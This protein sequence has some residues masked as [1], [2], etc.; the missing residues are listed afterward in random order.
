MNT[1]VITFIALAFFSA[2][3][4]SK[5]SKQ[6]PTEGTGPWIVNVYYK[7]LK[8]LQ[9]FAKEQEPWSVNTK[10]SYFTTEVVNRI[11]YQKLIND[12]F[13]IEVNTKRMKS[14]LVIKNAI[15]KAQ[16]SSLPLDTKTVPGLA[17]YRT[18]EETFATMDQLATTYPTL[19]TVL[20]VGDTWNKIDSGGSAGY[21]IRVLKI[22]NTAISG[23]KPVLFIMSSIHAREMAPAELNTRFAEYLLNNYG[24]NADVTW[25]VNNREIHLLLQGNPDGRKIA[26]TGASKRKNEDNIFCTNQSTKGVDMNRNFEWMWNQGS[27]SSDVPCEQTFRGGTNSATIHDYEPEN[28]AINTHMNDIFIDQRG[29]GLS[30]PAPNDTTGVYIDIHSYSELVLWPYGYDSPGV[31]PEAPNHNQLQT[32]GRKFAWYNDYLPEKSNELYGA[33]GASDDNAYGQLGIASYTFELGTSFFQDCGTFENTILPDNLKALIYAAKVA[34]TPY[35]TASG[36]DIDNLLVSS[37]TDYIFIGDVLTVS[38]VATDSHFSHNLDTVTHPAETEQNISKAEFF[39][40]E[41]PWDVGATPIL[42]NAVDGNFN[43]VTENF[44]GQIDTTGMSLGQHVVYV[45]TTDASGVTGVPYAKFFTIVDAADLGTLS[46]TITDAATNLP[47]DAVLLSYNG[48]QANSNASGN[49]SFTSLASTTDLTVSKQGYASEI[50]NNVSIVASQTT[51][52]NIQLQ[53]LCALLD[54]SSETFNVIADAQI[55][56]WS[57][58]FAAGVDDWSI[59]LTGGISATHAF[60]TSDPGATTDKWL[61]TP[62]MDLSADSVLEFWHKFGFEGTSTFYDGGI[63]E[64][65]TNASYSNWVDLGS[66]ASVGGY[67]VT[68]NSGNPLGAIQ[69]WGGSQPAFSRVEISLSSFAGT[70]AKIRWRMGADSS[71]GGSAPWVIDDIKVL[72]PNVCTLVNPD[73]LFSSGFEF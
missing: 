19:A 23:T 20:D 6:L 40:D 26:E 34:D 7:D 32:L 11:Q 17:C 15:K 70:S 18:V 62:A 3:V 2:L 48:L 35:I 14:A 43:A 21:D 65:A 46:G 57:H 67:N 29:P 33:D 56:G 27:G 72:D 25:L 31:I 50:I 69:A 12:G 59:N 54:E 13:L 53:P 36:P 4:F 16:R 28:L 52:Q 37:N 55:V 60:S 63:L 30:D 71:V 61:I 1:K 47:V 24:S 41:N 66:L 45:Q 42:L 5:P 64:I 38:G 58:G 44:T 73:V 9:K 8:Q 49:Y 22:T 10:K 68:L 39:L 51:T